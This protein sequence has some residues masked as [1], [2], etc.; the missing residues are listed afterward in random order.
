MVASY[1]SFWDIDSRTRGGQVWESEPDSHDAAN[2]VTYL[3]APVHSPIRL[4]HGSA[5]VELRPGFYTVCSSDLPITA[6]CGD[7]NRVVGVAEAADLAPR[8]HIAPTLGKPLPIT[9]I[10]LL[11]LRHVETTVHVAGSLTPAALAAAADAANG[12]MTALLSGLPSAV[13]ADAVA[14]RD[15]IITYIEARLRDPGLDIRQVAAAHHVSPRTVYRIFERSGDSVAAHIRGRRLDRCRAEIID[16]PDLS[17]ATICARW[18][19]GDAKHLAGKYRARFGESPYET[20]QRTGPVRSGP[21]D[22]RPRANPR[23]CTLGNFAH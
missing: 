22:H 17:L 7:A 21:D 16:R 20:R 6:E 2:P 14:L 9:D 15:R 12:L 1:T 23:N 3:L 18:A 11:L 4:R 5:D 19:V 13:V 10:G 8:G